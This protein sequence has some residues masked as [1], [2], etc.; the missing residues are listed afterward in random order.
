VNA[1]RL[2]LRFGTSFVASDKLTTD[3]VAV[4]IMAEPYARTKKGRRTIKVHATAFGVRPTGSSPVAL[5]WLL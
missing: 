5:S 1:G 3:S 4:S 2:P